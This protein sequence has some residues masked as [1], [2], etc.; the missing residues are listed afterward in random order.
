MKTALEVI[1]ESEL[2]FYLQSAKG[3]AFDTCHK[4]Y[5]LMDD[6]QMA[7]MREYGY[8][9]LITSDEMSEEEMYRTVS[10]WYEDSCSLRFIQA[11]ETNQE[12]PNAGFS[13][14]VAQGAEWEDEDDED[15]EE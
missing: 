3:I 10:E 2:E 7:L 15:E 5:V 12:N 11:V 9:T 14:I 1:A 6:E 8:D 4:I 13:D